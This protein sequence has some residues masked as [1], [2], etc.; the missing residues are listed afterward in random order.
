ML[1]RWAP[2]ELRGRS[3]N[4]LHL[5][6]EILGL[7]DEFKNGFALDFNGVEFVRVLSLSMIVNPRIKLTDPSFRKS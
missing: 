6:Q 5:F 3:F 2:F 7:T 1:R 4:R